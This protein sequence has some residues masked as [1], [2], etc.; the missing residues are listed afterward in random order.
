MRTRTV[1][2]R[3][4]ERHEGV[5]RKFMSPTSFFVTCYGV[6]SYTSI[7]YLSGYYNLTLPVQFA[8]NMW[9]ID[10]KLI[11]ADMRVPVPPPDVWETIQSQA[12]NSRL[13][14]RLRD[15]NVVEFVRRSNDGYV[16]WNKLRF[17]QHCQKDSTPR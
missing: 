6:T 9:N 2:Y 14:Q 7:N 15:P 13:F 17:Y 1:S 10:N 12:A 3:A 4:R 5:A 8:I 16:H 11:G